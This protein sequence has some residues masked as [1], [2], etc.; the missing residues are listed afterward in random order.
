LDLLSENGLTRHYGESREGF[1]Q[2][3]A[4]DFPSFQGLTWIQLEAVLG[5]GRSPNPERQILLQTLS[6]NVGENIPL[7]RRM[8][9]LLNP[10]SPFSSK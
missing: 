7:W 10:F 3:L 5:D 2:R 4:D 1:A 6:K 9:G 8:L